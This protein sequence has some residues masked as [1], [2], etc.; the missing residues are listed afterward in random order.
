MA[1]ERFDYLIIGGGPAG[2]EAAAIAAERGF[3]TALVE[4]D[5][6]GGTCLNRGCIPTKCMCTTAQVAA[7]ISRSAGL[8][9]TLP[10]A[11]AVTPDMPTIVARKNSVVEQLRQ[12]VESILQKV[13]IIRGEARFTG[14]KSVLV[15]GREIEGER[16]LIAT[17]SETAMLDIPGAELAITSNEALN[18]DRLPASIAIIGGGV[19]GMEFASIFNEL[20]V[21]VT[22]LEY[23]REI[24]P[25]F[26]RDVAKRLR[27]TLK[28]RGIEFHTGAAVESITRT[29]G[30]PDRVTYTEKGKP[31]TA[32]AELVLMAVGRR[33]VIPAGA[34]EAGYAIGPKGFKVNESMMTNIAGTWAIG[35]CNGICQ[36]AHAAT[37]QARMVMGDNVDLSVIPSA[38]FTLPECAMVG[39]TGEQCDLM[40]GQAEAAGEEPTRYVEGKAFFRA[41][42]KACAMGETDGLV[43]VI[44]NASTGMLAGCHICGPH[45]SDLIAEAALAMSARLTAAELLSAVHAHPTLSEALTAAIDQATLRL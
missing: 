26:D 40:R 27:T 34:A 38:L 22:V 13:E 15:S 41:N 12:G 42:G 32:E 7:D 23:A 24:L 37:A 39:L 25:Q 3:K 33:A 14:E 20:G 5:Q 1:T 45:A 8:G 9:L 28:Q 16:V 10:G 44:L 29:A 18:L 31:G 43:K 36:L 4:R 11:T 6:L 19:I 30:E 35:D 21:K 17:G 2:Y